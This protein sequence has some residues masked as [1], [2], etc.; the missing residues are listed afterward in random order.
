M[1]NKHQRVIPFE[2]IANFRDLGGYKAGREKMVAWRRLYR[3]GGIDHMSTNDKACLKDDIRLKTVIELANPD[4]V[5]KLR[6]IRLLEEIGAR[7]FHIPFR[8]DI[9]DYYHKELGLYKNSANMGVFY[10]GRIGH[11]TFACKLIQILEIMAGLEY[12]PLLFHCAAG[13]DRTGVLAAVTLKLLGVSDED[14]IADY[15]LTDASMEDVRQR[16]CSNPETTDEIR[17]LP[18][19]TWRA[20]P[21]FIQTFL[22]GLKEEYGS[23]AGYLKKY[24]AQKDLVKRLEKVL[25]V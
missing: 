20:M 24:G 14:I 8:P 4:D 11:E 22:D 16:I 25:L 5:K 17:N 21:Q 2:S 9:P 1:E 15:V 19:F 3:S 10:L 12:Y 7:Y 6:E 18:D 13:K 23:A